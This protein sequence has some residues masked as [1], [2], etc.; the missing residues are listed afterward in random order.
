MLQ[1]AAVAYF[2]PETLDVF[3]TDFPEGRAPNFAC[4]VDLIGITGKSRSK[5]TVGEVLLLAVDIGKG[6][7]V[8][9]TIVRPAEETNYSRGDTPDAVIILVKAGAS[10]I[11]VI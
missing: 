6:I 3:G 1:V 5:C 8:V 11:E 2:P 4:V 10:A 9:W 7:W